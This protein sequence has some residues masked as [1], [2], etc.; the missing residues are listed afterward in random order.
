MRGSTRHML[1]YGVEFIETSLGEIVPDAP[2][3]GDLLFRRT[4]LMNQPLEFPVS[5]VDDAAEAFDEDPEL[6]LVGSYVLGTST[7]SCD[8]RFAFVHCLLSIVGLRE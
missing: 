3:Q 8:G 5:V 1:S 4:S 6:L 7:R 2:E